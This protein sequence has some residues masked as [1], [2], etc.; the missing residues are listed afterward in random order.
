M[1][2][3]IPERR[4]ESSSGATHRDGRALFDDKKLLQRMGSNIVARV[5][6][7]TVADA[8][9]GFRA[10]SRDAAARLNVFSEYTYT[11]E[12]IIQAGQKN[13]SI[14]SVPVRVN[15]DLRPSRLVR[16]IFSYVRVHS[17]SSDP[18]HLSPRG[19]LSEHGDDPVLAG[20]ALGVRSLPALR[21]GR[22]GNINPSF[23]RV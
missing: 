14:V 5:S 23:W 20:I 8:P 19:L 11:L 13:M 1:I 17:P 2:Q 21:E 3:P 6:G 12:T 9:S 10:F 16:S 7:T 22:A 4:A 15:A 18:H